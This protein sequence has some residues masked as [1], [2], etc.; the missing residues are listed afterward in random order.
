MPLLKAHYP[1]T[2]AH[3]QTFSCRVPVF[4][5]LLPVLMPSCGL[6]LTFALQ[7]I[8]FFLSRSGNLELGAANLA[9]MFDFVC[10]LLPF[11]RFGYIPGGF[12]AGPL[13]G[14]FL[15]LSSS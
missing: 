11:S 13:S 3:L 8:A 10:S 5:P 4:H 14:S 9:V 2:Y 7:E 6:S 15:R 12:P 1:I